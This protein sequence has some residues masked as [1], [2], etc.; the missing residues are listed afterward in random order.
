MQQWGTKIDILWFYDWSKVVIL[1]PCGY[2]KFSNLC[3]TS[4]LVAASRSSRRRRA[5]ISKRVVRSRNTQCQAQPNNPATE[6]THHSRGRSCAAEKIENRAPKRIQER[7]SRHLLPR[8]LPPTRQETTH[9]WVGTSTSMP[10]SCCCVRRR[11][12]LLLW[13]R[14]PAP[15]KRGTGY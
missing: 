15:A 5:S 12:L 8:R 11:V 9:S 4:P 10:P 14:Q 6:D 1:L 2:M 3:G 7:H 13:Q